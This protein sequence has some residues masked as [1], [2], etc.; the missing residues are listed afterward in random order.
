MFFY[1]SK[2]LWFLVNPGNLLLIGLIIGIVLLWTRW[3]R[4]GH[5]LLAFCTLLALIAS[6]APVGKSMR[7]VLENRFPV[8]LELPEKVDGILVLGGIV[9]ETI[10][11][12]RGQITVGGAISRLIEF[13]I[14]SKRYPDA[15]LVFTGGSGK[16][17]SQDIKEADVLEP[18]LDV[19]GVDTERMIYE[20][21]SRNTY[22]NATL[23]KALIKPGRDENWILITSAFHMPRSMGVFRKAGW[24]VIPYPVDYSYAIDEP[25]S[26]VFDLQNGLM[27][28]SSGLHEWLGLIFY[29][30]N[31]KTDH[32][33]P[34]P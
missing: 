10:T 3:R 18:L 30:L 15:K 12:S 14:L 34:A 26:P 16:L 9:N 28:L 20:N 33:F 1:L 21:K 13:A 27:N 19:L 31:G 23:S 8:N 32:F 22:E 11:K 17:L 24:N 6:V 5:L 29:R 25:L 7:I 4:A 2:I